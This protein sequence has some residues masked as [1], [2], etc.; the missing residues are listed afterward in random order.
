MVEPK[1]PTCKTE[2][3]VSI[4]FLEQQNKEIKVSGIKL[5][6]CPKCHPEKFHKG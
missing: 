1:C 3:K 4:E 2:M 5:Y 6:H